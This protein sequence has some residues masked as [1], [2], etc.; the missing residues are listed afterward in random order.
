VD[1]MECYA[2]LEFSIDVS[3]MQHYFAAV[4]NGHWIDIRDFPMESD[5]KSGIIKELDEYACNF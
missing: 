5:L 2:E 4:H 3:D 1:D